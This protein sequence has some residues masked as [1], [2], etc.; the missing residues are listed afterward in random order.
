MSGK[1][2]STGIFIVQHEASKENVGFVMSWLPSPSERLGQLHWLCVKPGHQDKGIGRYLVCKV[3]RYFRD[4]IFVPV[5]F[6]KTEKFRKNAIN[7]Y[8]HF[9]FFCQ[10]QTLDAINTT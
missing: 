10:T 1:Y 9:G 8:K 6:L 2:Q 4:E 7:L 5:V 3:L